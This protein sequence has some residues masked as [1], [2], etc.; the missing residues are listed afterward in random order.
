[1]SNFPWLQFALAFSVV[2]SASERVVAQ[3]L[4]VNP[5]A[6]ASDVRNPSSTN[7]SAAASDVRNPSATN[8]PPQRLK[9]LSRAQDLQDQLTWRRSSRASAPHHRHVAPLRFSARGRTNGY[10]AGLMLRQKWSDRS[11]RLRALG[12]TASSLRSAR[13]RTRPSSGSW[14][15]SKKLSRLPTREPR[16]QSAHKA[17][18]RAPPC[19]RTRPMYATLPDRILA[20]RDLTTSRW[21][22]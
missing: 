20:S 4:G 11:K 22:A 14:R 18:G 5:S 7:P 3:A 9:F 13:L 15:R 1:M 8:P 16:Q 21:G 19:R 6:A 12:S 10:P 2:F 17:L